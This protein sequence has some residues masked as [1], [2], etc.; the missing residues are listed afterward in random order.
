MTYM[1]GGKQFV[2]FAVGSNPPRL[3]ALS[4]PSIR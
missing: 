4:L 2:T 3:V 1:V